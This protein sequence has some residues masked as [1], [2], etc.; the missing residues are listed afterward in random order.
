MRPGITFTAPKAS[1]TA[2][3]RAVDA[4]PKH[5]GP[6]DRLRVA[7]V[8]AAAADPLRFDLS[9]EAVLS[10][11]R[12]LIPTLVTALPP[13]LRTH[14]D[15]GP[16]LAPRL[17]ARLSGRTPDEAS[18]HVLTRHS[19]CWSTTTWPPPRS[20]SGSPRRPAPTRTRPSRPVSAP[21]RDLCTAR[22]ARSPTGCSP[23][24]WT[25]AA[26]PP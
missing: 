19:G 13:I 9:E 3:R 17:W 23:T 15:S 26:R 7:A 5:S 21:L 24:C 2:A 8:A 12:T 25:T 16:L 1:A 4:L 18:L 10:T 22:P 14:R 11:A 20:P 6:V